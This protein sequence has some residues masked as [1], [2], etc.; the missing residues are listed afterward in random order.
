MSTHILTE[1]DQERIRE[2]VDHAETQTAGEIV[3]YIINRSGRYEIAFWRG[4]ALG[5]LI[6]G[7]VGLL[8]A[9]LYT[10]WAL[11][12]LCSALGLACIRPARGVTYI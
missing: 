9:W 1:A 4:G 5:A 12:W 3:P 10:G 8:V 6:A 7:A 11:G 2:A